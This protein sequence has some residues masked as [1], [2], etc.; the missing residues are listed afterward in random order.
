MLHN[1][2]H[3]DI[4][5]RVEQGFTYTHRVLAEEDLGKYR[6]EYTVDHWICNGEMIRI[7]GAMPVNDGILVLDKRVTIQ[8]HGTYI[9][10]VSFYDVS[11]P[12][13]LK[14]SIYIDVYK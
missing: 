4:R 2:I 9:L 11:T 6:V 5:D 8:L 14:Q 10:N 1:P 7:L 12:E 3:E 13:I